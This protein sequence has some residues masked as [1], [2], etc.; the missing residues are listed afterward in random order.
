MHSP[1]SS[2]WDSV[3]LGPTYRA[4]LTLCLPEAP[5]PLVYELTFMKRLP[6]PGPVL[7]SSMPHPSESSPQPP[8]GLL[9]SLP[10]LQ[11]EKLRLG[12]VI[13]HTQHAQLIGSRGRIQTEV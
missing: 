1:L 4:F 7:G 13:Y 9:L 2:A 12:E 3:P 5:S 8:K 6:V 11:M 10:I